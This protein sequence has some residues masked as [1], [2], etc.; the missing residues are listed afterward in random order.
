MEPLTTRTLT[1]D[2][3]IRGFWLTMNDQGI[4]FRWSP[5][6]VAKLAKISEN[7]PRRWQEEPAWLRIM[8]QI[9][10]WTVL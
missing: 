4:R 1:A 8:P 6:L 10:T 7:Q 5:A 2:E 3:I 9:T